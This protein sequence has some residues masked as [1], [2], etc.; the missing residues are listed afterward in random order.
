VLAL[1]AITPA[2][3]ARA[4]RWD[5]VLYLEMAERGIRGN[6]TLVAPFAY[7]I[8][9]PLLARWL[10]RSLHLSVDDAFRAVTYAGLVAEL[11]LVFA[12]ARRMAAS[13]AAAFV[14]MAV[15]AL[16]F[17]NVR[18]LLFDVYRPDAVALALTL[19]SALALIGRHPRTAALL[20]AMGL[21]VREFLLAP[22]VAAL[23]ALVR[24]PRSAM[25]S[26]GTVAVPI[27]VAAAAVVL[28]RLLVP[29]R[30]SA[31]TDP[32]RVDVVPMLLTTPLSIRRDVNVVFCVASYFL[33]TLALCGSG[34]LRAAWAS[35]ADARRPVI[36][37]AAVTITLVLYGGTDLPRFTAYFV[38][39]QTIVLAAVLR[40]RPSVVEIATTLAAVAVFNRAYVVTVALEPIDRYLD[41]FGG[42]GD[43]VN[44]ATARRALELG[45][46]VAAVRLVGMTAHAN[47]RT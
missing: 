25:R 28:P 8:V 2:F 16:S 23:D 9:T 15:A 3:D 26:V 17:F 18:F 38:V 40:Q 10:S 30:P 41:L 4:H 21:L 43:R 37:M 35:L 34:R 42:Y 11:A 20:A 45:G 32:F 24:G 14:V 39:V 7:R 27:A 47:R 46:W 31:L 13:T 33:P 36:I 1:D 5:S 44:A 12:L 29:A 6:E 19:L 22:L